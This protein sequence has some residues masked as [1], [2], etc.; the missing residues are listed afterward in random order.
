MAGT[1]NVGKRKLASE[2]WEK[3]A[4]T[5]DFICLDV[6]YLLYLL[7]LLCRNGRSHP[8]SSDIIDW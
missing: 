1:V 2:K 6:L 3:E 7:Y 8:P 5:R 4:S